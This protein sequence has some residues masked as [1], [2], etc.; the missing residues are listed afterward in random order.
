MNCKKRKRQ[1]NR[2]CRGAILVV[3]TV[4]LC[5]ICSLLLF[6]SYQLQGFL[7]V[8]QS[9][10]SAAESAVLAVAGD[11]SRIVEEDDN[12]GFVALSDHPPCGK[13]TLA[14]DGESLPVTGI[15]SLLA[16][17]RIEKILAVALQNGEMEQLA[18]TDVILANNAAVKLQKLLD[19]AITWQNQKKYSDMNGESIK[20]YEHAK[21]LFIRNLPDLASGRARLVNFQLRLGK[22]ADGSTS[23]TPDP[24]HK[25]KSYPGFKNMASNSDNLSLAG[26]SEQPR[27][28]DPSRFQVGDDKCFRSAVLLEA[29]VTYYS[30]DN[31][32]L[33]DVK[34]VAAALPFATVDRAAPAS[35]VLSLPQG[36]VMR[37]GNLRA[38]LTDDE[39]KKKRAPLFRSAGG[40]Y[41]VE[42]TAQLV[43]EKNELQ[44]PLSCSIARAIFDWLRTAKGR[45]N[46]PSLLKSFDEP[47][48]GS[49]RICEQ[50]TLVMY[51]LDGN[52]DCI[53]QKFNN[54]SL[55]QRSVSE[56]QTYVMVNNVARTEKGMLGVTIR[57]QVAR[58]G[59]LGGG[60]HGGQPIVCELPA[61]CQPP[62]DRAEPGVAL[63]QSYVS[64][65]L[66]VAIELFMT[67]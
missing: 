63:R 62:H 67:P 54:V 40:D 35:L 32:K 5:I 7:R 21:S 39:F 37:A 34:T 20:P 27:L 17:A 33:Y 18:Q 49:G 60:K 23:I 31:Q 51:N 19:S 48:S 61:N 44:R 36:G 43:E 11:L 24:E 26:V 25:G 58:W 45:V 14:S 65:G 3:G 55:E 47:F 52:G 38:L 57:D 10:R 8:Q 2:C 64:G 29:T 30:A 28:V 42:K 46:L 41:P 12:F 4:G 16:I 9:S 66:A 13:A 22:L 59:T 53:R 15:N 50:G 6:L 1:S 56:S